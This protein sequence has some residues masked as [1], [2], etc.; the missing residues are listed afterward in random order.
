VSQLSRRHVAVG[1]IPNLATAWFQ[2]SWSQIHFIRAPSGKSGSP[3][4]ALIKCAIWRA[5]LLQVPLDRADVAALLLRE[6][7]GPTARNRLQRRVDVV[8]REAL[9]ARLDDPGSGQGLFRIRLVCWPVSA[10]G[11]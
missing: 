4:F 11:S 3:A 8:V 1:R 2:Y 6:R 9:G 5:A 10:T 7:E